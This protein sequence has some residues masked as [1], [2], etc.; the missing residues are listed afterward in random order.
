MSGTLGSRFNGRVSVCYGR[1][2]NGWWNPAGHGRI[3]G[4]EPVD[5]TA[6]DVLATTTSGA[7]T[8]GT[9]DGIHAAGAVLPGGDDLLLGHPRA[10]ADGGGAGHPH[11]RRRALHGATGGCGHEQREWVG[12]QRRPP[13]VG[14]GER[15]GDL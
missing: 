14:E 11:R 8:C 3:A 2:N 4:V 12:R 13:V 5:E 10:A 7:G 6:D 15:R 1:V 9:R